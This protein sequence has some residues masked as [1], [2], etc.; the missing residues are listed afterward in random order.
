MTGPDTEALRTLRQALRAGSDPGDAVDVALIM[1]RGRRLRRRRRVAAV[2][3]T[4]CAL[5]V[6]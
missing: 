4:L 2:A 1:D 6:P 3:G 5:A